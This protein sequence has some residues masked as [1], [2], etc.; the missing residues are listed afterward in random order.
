M[1][2][3][4]TAPTLPAGLIMHS[5]TCH[6]A[7][8]GIVRWGAILDHADM[9]RGRSACCIPL[10]QLTWPGAYTGYGGRVP[11]QPGRKHGFTRPVCRNKHS[12]RSGEKVC[13]LLLT[14][15]CWHAWEL[16]WKESRGLIREPCPGFK[17]PWSGLLDP[18]VGSRFRATNSCKCIAAF[19]L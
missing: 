8:Q 11:P 12:S 2:D 15:Y 17:L 18:Q 16:P 5:P 4:C 3:P 6:T 13:G 9:A 10:W 7:M 1:P 14:R 19:L